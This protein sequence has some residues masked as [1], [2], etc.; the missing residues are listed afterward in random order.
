MLFVKETLDQVNKTEQKVFIIFFYG[1]DT[2]IHTDVCLV[3][4]SRSLVRVKK[5]NKIYSIC[6]HYYEKKKK[7]PTSVKKK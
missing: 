3:Y 1:M 6:S 2:H 5:T 7:K 4:L